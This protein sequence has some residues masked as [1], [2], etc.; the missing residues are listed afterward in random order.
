MDNPTKE[1][2]TLCVICTKP[3]TEAEFQAEEVQMMKDGPAHADCYYA[4]FGKEIDEHPICS[5][6]V[7]RG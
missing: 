5:P 1:T 3:I 2:K 4:E 6:R 7:R